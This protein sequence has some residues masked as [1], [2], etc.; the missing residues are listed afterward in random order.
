MEWKQYFLRTVIMFPDEPPSSV[1]QKM[2]R[3]CE[4]SEAIQLNQKC[5]FINKN[6][7]CRVASLLAMT[8]C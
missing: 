2:S 4:R 6:L 1:A 8:Y 7:D 5:L 3:H